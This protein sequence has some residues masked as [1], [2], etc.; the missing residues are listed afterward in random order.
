MQ[1]FSKSIVRQLV[2]LTA[3]VAS[4]I[5]HTLFRSIKK[6][7]LHFQTPRQYHQINMFA[8]LMACLIHIGGVQKKLAL[9]NRKL[10]PLTCSDVVV[11]RDT[12]LLLSPTPYTFCSMNHNLICGEGCCP[13]F[14]FHN[15]IDHKSGPSETGPVGAALTGLIFGLSHSFS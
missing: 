4:V 5:D 7:P 1:L 3:W 9:K 2:Y 14:S 10:K 15:F 13:Y 6:T 8:C 11:V 12:V